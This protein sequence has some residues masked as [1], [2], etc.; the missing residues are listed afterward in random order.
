M[1]T[2]FASEQHL[3]TAFA[4]GLEGL[5]A[6]EQLGTFILVLANAS[7]DETLQRRLGAALAAQ[8]ERLHAT[9]RERLSRGDPVAAVEEDLSVFLKLQTVGLDNLPASRY[10]TTGPWQLQF[11]LLRAFRPRRIT[12]QA[13]KGIAAPYDPEAFNFNKPFLQKEAFWSGPIGGREATLYYNKYPFADLHGLLVPEREACH[14]QR[15]TDKHHRYA[16]EVAAEA[17]AGLPGVGLGYNG[18]GAFASVNHLH[19][20]LFNA[21]NGLPVVDPRWRHN[22]GAHPYPAEC[23]AFD[24]REAAWRFLQ[25]L[26]EAEIPHNALYLPGRCY[27]F[28]RRPQGSYRQ[29]EWTS[30][31]TWYELAGGFITFNRE[32]FDRI[33]PAEIETALT[34]TRPDGD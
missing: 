2:L 7:V 34:A 19:F 32:Q 33:D 13:P 23:A 20:Q 11:N 5:L 6:K 28:P 16:W 26:Q 21:P 14:P 17:G 3:R 15:L 25:R 29:P 1:N 27:L 30:G 18:Y 22:G 8:S 31:F 10:R 9:C 12:S 4:D 24:E